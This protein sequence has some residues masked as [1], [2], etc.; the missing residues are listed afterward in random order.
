MF[1]ISFQNSS[2]V[3]S[4]ADL[5]AFIAAFQQQVSKDFAPVWGVD[6]IVDAG[7]NGWPITIRDYPGPNDPSGSLGYHDLGHNFQPYGVVFAK[8]ALDN[9]ISWT[10]V[11]SHEGL[12]TLADPLINSTVFVDTSGGYGTSGFL[13][14]LEVCDAP[15]SLSYSINGV[16]VSDF[17]YPGWFVPGYTGQC[18]QLRQVAGPLRLLHGGYIGNNQIIRATGW[19]DATASKKP[20]LSATSIQFLTQAKRL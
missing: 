11:A 18:D 17:V 8:L 10:S 4:E 7:G 1:H 15:E 6:A 20:V 5:Q 19:R 2:S 3:L 14:A 13:I 12:E 9:G 16:Q